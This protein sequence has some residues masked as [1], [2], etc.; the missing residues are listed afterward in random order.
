MLYR[1]MKRE[2]KYTNKKNP[3]FISR[4]K[5][6]PLGE[7]MQKICRKKEKKQCQCKTTQKGCLRKQVSSACNFSDV[8][9]TLLRGQSQSTEGTEALHSPHICSLL[10]QNWESPVA[11]KICTMVYISQ[12]IWSGTY[13]GKLETEKLVTKKWPKGRVSTGSRGQCL[14]WIQAPASATVSNSRHHVKSWNEPQIS[15]WFS[16][17]PLCC[18]L[19]QK[20]IH[21][22]EKE[23]RSSKW[24]QLVDKQKLVTRAMRCSILKATCTTSFSSSIHKIAKLPTVIFF[25]EFKVNEKCNLESKVPLKKVFPFFFF[26]QC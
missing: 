20:H 15:G 22:T 26:E 12:V 16:S 14:G 7:A 21:S 1:L 6:E 25:E 3:Y 19:V 4:L 11:L 8:I 10:I 2:R 24:N 18:L 9:F 13:F 5:P 17:L 23:N